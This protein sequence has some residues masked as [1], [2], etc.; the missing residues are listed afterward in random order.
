[1][2]NNIYSTAYV[3]D[4]FEPNKETLKNKGML[5]DLI[6]QLENDIT[7][8]SWSKKTYT[9]MDI[10][11]MPLMIAGANKKNPNLHL[12]FLNNP[13]DIGSVIENMMSQTK[14]SFRCITNM[15]E[16]G[17]HF[18]V[19]EGRI[20][21]NK[22][23]LILFDSSN[24]HYKASNLLGIRL[25]LALENPLLP[26]CF[27]VM[28]AMNIQRSTSDC[29]IFSLALAKKIHHESEIIDNIHQKNIAG[30]FKDTAGFMFCHEIDKF[31]PP[32]LFKHVQSGSR[33]GE[34]IDAHPESKSRVIN[35]KG[36]S[37]FERFCRNL[38]SVNNKEM[39]ISLH[40]KRIHEY[41]K[42]FK[43]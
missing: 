13:C 30:E 29:G 9:D 39:S 28:F 11:M 26:E 17:I 22:I 20:I 41:S 36:E 35:K 31:L 21:N 5:I 14:H 10:K 7:D 27:F 23:S 40:K 6:K 12:E 15:G 8:G 37:I 4:M 33:L 42:A 32:S 2:L 19:I 3:N 24:R 34:Y 25:T 16:D 43:I 1:M 18:A 38:V